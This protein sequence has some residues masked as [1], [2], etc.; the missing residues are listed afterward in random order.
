M[1]V[2]ERLLYEVVMYKEGKRLIPEY[3]TEVSYRE[4]EMGFSLGRNGELEGMIP[5][6][7]M[8]IVYLSVSLSWFCSLHIYPICMSYGNDLSVPITS[9]AFDLACV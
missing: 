6:I 4:K 3:S 9:N 1:C 7:F 5:P 2:E 8:L